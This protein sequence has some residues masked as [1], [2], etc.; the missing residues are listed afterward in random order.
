MAGGF[1]NTIT[2]PLWIARLRIQTQH[3]NQQSKYK[4]LLQTLK[5]IYKEEGV[6]NGLFK[7]LL[8]SYIGLIHPMIYFPIYEAMKS[9]FTDKQKS[10]VSGYQITICSLVA[11]VIA[12]A[13]TYPHII[14]RNRVQFASADSKNHGQIMH[15]MA[16]IVKL[17]YKKQGMR[18]F[19]TG[20][21]FEM[22]RVLP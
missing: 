16:D 8:V 12:I 18:G 1:T 9:S 7:G 6:K 17:T 15:L 11:K 4:G 19:Y 22:F 20:I 10:Q 21:S 5:L 14:V 3:L 13:T 2:N